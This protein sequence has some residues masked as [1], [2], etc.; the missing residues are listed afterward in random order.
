MAKKMYFQ[1]EIETMPVEQL[2]AL[3]EEA[4]YNHRNNV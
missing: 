4:A 1:E 3:Q 2:K